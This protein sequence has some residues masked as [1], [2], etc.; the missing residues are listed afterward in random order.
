[1][2]RRVAHRLYAVFLLAL[3][4]GG[5]LGL[6]AADELLY[7]MGKNAP[8]AQVDHFD[9]AGGCGSHGEH[10]VLSS[11]SSIRPHTIV[12]SLPL[13]IDTVTQSQ[14]SFRLVALLRSLDRSL[15][16]PS[17]APPVSAS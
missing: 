4:A 12:S 13:R 15:L 11:F 17:R 10:C 7:H 6:P 14:A 16:K 3:F 8:G 2:N 9:A 1:M 5:E